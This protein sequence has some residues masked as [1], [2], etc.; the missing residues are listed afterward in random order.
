[1]ADNV[2]G[3]DGF[4]AGCGIIENVP[5][6]THRKHCSENKKFIRKRIHEFAE[7]GYKVARTGNVTVQKIRYRGEYKQHRCD[8]TAGIRIA[9]DIIS[10]EKH[11]K[12]DNADAP[13]C[14]FIR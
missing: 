1:M 7:I 8:N 14:Q 12:R 6:I 11:K 2:G 3:N 9:A 4:H 5:G 13:D 10:E